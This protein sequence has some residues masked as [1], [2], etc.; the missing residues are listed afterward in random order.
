[1]LPA[2]HDNSIESASQEQATP[3]PPARQPHVSLHLLSHSDAKDFIQ[4]I[5]DTAFTDS[6]VVDER[7]TIVV[8][9]QTPEEWTELAKY[10]RIDEWRPH[11]LAVVLREAPPPMTITEPDQPQV[12]SLL[13]AQT[14][15]IFA[16]GGM[17]VWGIKG[18]PFLFY[19]RSMQ[20]VFP[21]S[22][23]GDPASYRGVPKLCCGLPMS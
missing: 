3:G 21:P 1:M 20:G 7:L 23:L 12:Q 19:L 11:V 13:A 18:V 22:C 9:S 14:A 10:V 17:L 5:G 2:P 8:Q 16:L 6:W 4:E 15:A